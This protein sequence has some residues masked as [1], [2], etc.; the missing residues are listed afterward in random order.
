MPKFIEVEV[1]VLVDG[2]EQAIASEDR[3]HCHERYAE[4]IGEESTTPRR[5]IRVM[6]KVP[7]PEIVQVAVEIPAEAGEV[8]GLA[9]RPP[10]PDAACLPAD[11]PTRG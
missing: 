10:P 11:P 3:D 7:V 6:L 2:D 8:L 5:L 9:L 1:W 4:Q